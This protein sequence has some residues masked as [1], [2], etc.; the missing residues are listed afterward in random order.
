MKQQR[1]SE[2][3][4]GQEHDSFKVVILFNSVSDSLHGDQKENE[5]QKGTSAGPTATDL[6]KFQIALTLEYEFD[7]L[8][9]YTPMEVIEFLKEMHASIMDKPYRKELSM[10]S[11]KG[12]RP[13]K[14]AQ[15]QGFNDNLSLTFISF[16]M[17][18]PGVSENKAIAIAKAFPTYSSLMM[19]FEDQKLTEQVKVARLADVE[20][21]GIGGEKAKKIGT[22][23]AKKVFQQLMAVDPTIV[24]N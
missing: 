2:D 1:E 18:I 22:A 21:R 14:K 6:Q 16:L 12:F 10:Y 11:R 20:I 8:E 9:V 15:I 3:I 5:Q 4:E 7:Y 24:I 19:V 17:C 13:G 23:I